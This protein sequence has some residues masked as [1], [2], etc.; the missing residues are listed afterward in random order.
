MLFYEL[1]LC[2]SESVGTGVDPR[3]LRLLSP[4]SDEGFRRLRVHRVRGDPAQKG[5][6]FDGNLPDGVQGK[7]C[8]SREEQPELSGLFFTSTRH[9]RARLKPRRAARPLPCWPLGV[10]A[11]TE[12]VSQ[13]RANSRRRGFRWKRRLWTEYL[14]LRQMEAE[15]LKEGGD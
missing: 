4:L 1:L 10:T 8:E 7:R 11:A 6:N 13:P 3:C 5:V 15:F 12:A 2:L 14:G 9:R